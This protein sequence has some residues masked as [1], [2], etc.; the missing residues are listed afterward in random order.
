IVAVFGKNLANQTMI[1]QETPLPFSL[2]GTS[3]SIKDSHGAVRPSPLFF[4][5]PYQIN[6]QISSDIAPGPPTL[7]L[8]PPAQFLALSS[9]S[10]KQVAPGL[11]TAD[12]TGGGLPAAVALRAKADGSQSYEAIL[13]LNEG[14]NKFVPIPIDL[15]PDLGAESDQ[16]FLVLFGTGIRHRS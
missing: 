16:V 15:G 8:P 12:A 1:A 4:V 2:D 10:I 9:V 13:R 6:Y 3:V 14:Q 7:S 5:S 11:V